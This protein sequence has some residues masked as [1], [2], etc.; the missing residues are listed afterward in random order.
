MP[1]NMKCFQRSFDV[2]SI[3][4]LTG[5]RAELY[6]KLRADVLR[7]IVFPAVRKNEL[8]FYYMGGCLYKFNGKAFFRDKQYEKHSQ[9]TDGLD[10][11]EKAKKQNENKYKR[12]DGSLKER[13]LLDKLNKF[14]F[15]PSLRSNVV[16][17]DIEV[18]L[19]GEIGGDKK[20][21]LV[22]LYTDRNSPN[23]L[24]KIMFVEGKVFSDNRVNVKVGS[25]PDV[26]EQ[27]N[28]YKKAIDEQSVGI[29]FEYANH[30]LVINQLFGT[31]YVAPFCGAL[32]N[33]HIFGFDQFVNNHLIYLVYETPEVLNNNG[34]QS[35]ETIERS[36]GR[37]NIMWV[38]QG[39]EPTLEEI[40][41]ALCK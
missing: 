5:E 10:D 35:I 21:D 18:R 11:Y 38:K 19:N 31:E 28:T 1:S 22:L 36:I 23:P 15:N 29:V 13:Q 32:Y 34:R 9:E 12:A 17:L 37:S 3:D 24:S 40:W 14:T 27:V 4:R 8:H 33:T 25:L 16:V 7:G 20:C 2:S 41:E 30:I 26:I 6:K 39:N